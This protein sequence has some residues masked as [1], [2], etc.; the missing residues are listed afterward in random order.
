MARERNKTAPYR[1][2]K[3]KMGNRY[4]FYC[5][6]SGALACIS[7][8][9]NSISGEKE[10]QMVWEHEG[11]SHFNQCHKCGK[12]VID[13]MYNADVLQC[14]DCAPWEN[15]PRFCPQCGRKVYSSGG[16]CTHCGTK[17]Q[18]K[19]VVSIFE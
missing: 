2:I 19:D 14:V 6:S 10:L 13:E 1:I 11:R 16:Y 17:L 12:W 15:R 9:M 5:E 7:K 4:C 8:P 18:Y 3:E